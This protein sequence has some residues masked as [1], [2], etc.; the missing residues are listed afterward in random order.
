MIPSLWIAKTGLDAQQINMNVISNN[1]AN[2]STNGF[3]KSHAIFEDLMY[4]TLRQPGVTCS[5]NSNIPSGLQL[6]TGVR[7]IATE[8]I[9]TQGN[10]SK[11]G[12]SKDLAINGQG[13]FQ[14]QLPNGNIAY[15]RDGS[16]QIDKNGQLGT[17]S[18][19]ALQPTVN[20]PLHAV[21]IHI[22]RD[23]AIFV[24]LQGEVNQNQIGQLNLV[25]FVNNAGLES[26]G[27]NL[28]KE[29]NASGSPVESAPG[30]NGA[31]SIYQGFV[32]TSNVNVAEELVNMIQTQRAYEINSKSINSSDQM[33]QKL[34]QL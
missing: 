31:G 30:S 3:K 28:Y 21:N 27:E 6:G 18:G 8:R 12:S 14:V 10:L 9:H 7:P 24:T 19:F 26:L 29:T 22:G 34:S 15:T 1:L 17:S 23:G 32:E 5:N 11:T 13:F 25:N 33:L 20:I 2:V 4:Q 16:F